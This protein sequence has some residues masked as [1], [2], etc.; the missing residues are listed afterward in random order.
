[1]KPRINPAQASKT[2]ALILCLGAS[3][4]ALQGCSHQSNYHVTEK[5]AHRV[6]IIER[7]GGFTFR[8]GLEEV[9]DVAII[10][11][12]SLFGDDAEVIIKNSEL[13]VNGKNY[14]TLKERDSVTLKENKVLI[15]DSE[16]QE[17]ARR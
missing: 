11:R 6:T 7:D 13:T 2:F 5:G 4:I 1:M 10:R 16:V 17:L 12:K 14:G 9:G 3:I 15:N 8:D